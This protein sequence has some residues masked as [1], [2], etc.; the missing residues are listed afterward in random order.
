M[1]NIMEFKTPHFV[2]VER[3]VTRV[4]QPPQNSMAKGQLYK[5]NKIP[6]KNP[7]QN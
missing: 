6:H 5:G 7:K 3:I 2:N 4:R 1:Q